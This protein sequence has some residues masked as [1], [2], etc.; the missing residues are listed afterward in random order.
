MSA[1]VD[2]ATGY[3]TESMLDRMSN[4]ELRAVR[5]WSEVE[6][7]RHLEAHVKHDAAGCDR[8]GYLELLAGACDDLL[9]DRR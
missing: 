3:Y 6:F 5:D 9:S 7:N 8:C 2:T 4:H 1:H